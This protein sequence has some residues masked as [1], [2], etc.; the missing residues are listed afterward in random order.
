MSINDYF[1][2]PPE[3]LISSLEPYQQEL[4]NELLK[5]AEGDFERAADLWL[6]ASPAQTAAFGGEKE[7]L[8]VYREKITDEIE[9][10]ICGTDESYSAEREKLQNNSDATQQYIVGVL[11]TAIGAHLGVAGAFIAPVIV[12]VIISFS[13]IALNAWCEMRKER[14]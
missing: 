12:L 3:F 11:S 7:H 8:K 5:A 9:K 1:Q 4:I 10:F 6:N 14:H 13:K 2:S